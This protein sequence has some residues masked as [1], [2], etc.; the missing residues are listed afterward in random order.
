LVVPFFN[1]I[2]PVLGWG[3]TFQFLELPVEIGNVQ[4][5]TLFGDH[6]NGK[7]V[8]LEEQSAC[9]FYPDLDQKLKEGLVGPFLEITAK[10]ILAHIGPIGHGIQRK[11]F[12]EM[13]QGKLEHI[14]HAVAL[15]VRVNF[16][17]HESGQGLSFGGDH[18]IEYV[19]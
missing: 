10:S 13:V 12:M 8:V 6:G 5:T 4:K 1:G 14:V 7:I 9:M 16:S 3:N 19:Q 15:V 17:I 11:G 18:D 2:S